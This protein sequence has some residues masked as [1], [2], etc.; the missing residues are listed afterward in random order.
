[1]GAIGPFVGGILL[2]TMALQAV[3]L[4]FA[5]PA[6]CGAISV[7]LLLRTRVGPQ[8]PGAIQASAKA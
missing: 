3:F 6:V 5:I 1:M 7:F 2:D 8:Q 4:I